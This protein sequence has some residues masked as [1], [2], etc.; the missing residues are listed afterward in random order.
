MDEEMGMDKMQV[1][2]MYGDD[3]VCYF[4]CK[5]YSEMIR[6]LHF[7]KKYEVDLWPSEFDED[8]SEEM[9]QKMAG[10]GGLVTDYYWNFGSDKHIQCLVVQ[11]GEY[12]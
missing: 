6:F 5:N 10:I 3:L 4:Y 1:R 7:C 12:E 8:I 9:H 2:I 11:I